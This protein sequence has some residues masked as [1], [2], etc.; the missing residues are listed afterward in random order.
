MMWKNKIF[1]DI[2]EQV[3]NRR[4]GKAISMLENHLLMNGGQADMEPLRNLKNDYQLMADYW[5][6]GF[7][8]D[9]RET[10]YNQLLRRLYVVTTNV[11]IHDRI[12]NSSFIS[13]SYNRARRAHE[14]W[15]VTALRQTLEN[16]VSDMAMVSLEPEHVRQ[17]KKDELCNAHQRMM[18]D[19]FDYIW[20]SRLWSDSLA[21]AFEDMLLSPTLDV[22]DQQLMVSAI[23]LSAMNAFCI[24]KFRVLVKVYRQA[25]DE[26]LRQR[27]LVGWVFCADDSV[28]RLYPEMQTMIGDLL[29]D[30]NVCTELTE[31]QMQMQFC[32][33]A[34]EDQ[35]TIQN[36]II[37]DLMR[38][39]NL[40]FNRMGLEEMEDD[41]LED[42]LHPDAAEMKMERMEES[43]HRMM[44]M[45]KKG[46]D[47]Y[48]AGFSQMKRFSFFSD[49]SNWFVPF[50]TDH[51]GISHI[52]NRSK[53]QRLLHTVM[54]LGAFCDSD[55]YSFALAFDQV[56]ERLPKQ[57][58]AMIEKG[59]AM[60]MPVGGEVSG[61]EQRKP[62]FIRRLYLQN[63]YRFFRLFPQRSD[64]TD[65]FSPLGSVFFSKK[66][67]HGTP[68]EQRM[69]EVASFLAKRYQHTAAV[70]VLS[71]VGSDHYDLGYHL[72]MGS[73]RMR[74]ED[75]LFYSP[76]DA[77][78][79]YQEAL[80]LDAANQRALMGY[81]RACFVSEDYE[82]ALEAY[83][84]LLQQNPDHQGAQLNAAVCLTNLGR[85]EEAQK[86][87]YKLNYLAP[88]DV[89]VMRVLA[90]TQT[91]GGKYE[92]AAKFYDKLL[93]IDKPQSSDMLNYGY[94][95]WFSG[96]LNSA[97]SMFRQ[98]LS[99]QKDASFSIEREF[100][101]HEHD[102][103]LAHGMGDVEIQ[104]MLDFL[105]R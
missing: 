79:N 101:E 61:D 32:M 104:L 51:P 56:L 19:L 45:Q 8:D 22:L 1:N 41:P 42:I 97:V 9:Q 4:L 46:S 47:I 67:F 81:A 28:V 83:E 7:P 40:T 15:S 85:T 100:M 35:K 76:I 102:M 16:Y 95:L 82:Q 23:T 88:D 62:A 18:S 94:C 38:G 57:M 33:S 21:D 50:Y 14:D 72:L 66:L 20:T 54:K 91:L 78:E 60:P 87:L 3:M 13:A 90:W 63:L 10:L 48:F 77:M 59:E 68:L 73:L 25:V 24:N 58:L 96:D 44:D 55:K 64:F 2:T 74:R 89:A 98:F 30:E 26:C 39:N 103:I 92:Q 86:L 80:K 49:V 31:L 75:A 84:Q 17:R 27:A 29:K 5:R 43:M 52:W 69:V 11:A 99:D 53:A 37:P 70:G 71:N 65:P 105:E 12:R 93:A 6:K 36:E 34:E